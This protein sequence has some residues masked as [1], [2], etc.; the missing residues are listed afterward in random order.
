MKFLTVTFFLLAVIFPSSFAA[1]QKPSP[2]D[3][4]L[5][6][7]RGNVTMADLAG[8]YYIR[9]SNGDLPNMLFSDV[10][11]AEAKLEE[12]GDFTLELESATSFS[13]VIKGSGRF[14]DIG[15][16]LTLLEFQGVDKSDGKQYSGTIKDLLSTVESWGMTGFCQYIVG[17]F[18]RF[19]SRYYWNGQLAGRVFFERKYI[20]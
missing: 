6:G 19:S 20:D 10:I 13:L 3:P 14:R 8:E 1:V 4:N 18:S 11:K 15:L 16:Y 7:C 9:D 2:P 17:D 5:V 12:N